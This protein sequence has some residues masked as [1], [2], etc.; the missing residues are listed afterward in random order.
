MNTVFRISVVL[1][2]T[3]YPFIYG[4]ALTEDV[5]VIQ[6]RYNTIKEMQGDFIQKSYIKDWKKH[7]NLRGSFL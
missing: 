4:W 1:L 5:R 7:R 3:F 6:E 2:L